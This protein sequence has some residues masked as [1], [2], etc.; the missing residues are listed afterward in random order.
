M[1]MMRYDR[2]G[3]GWVSIAFA[4]P[5]L[6]T[7]ARR[8]S[9]AAAHSAWLMDARVAGEI[10]LLGLVSTVTATARWPKDYLAVGTAD[11]SLPER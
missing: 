1:I 2:T 5:Q 6:K 3:H 4:L 7:T 8:T 10:F 9:Q 11:F